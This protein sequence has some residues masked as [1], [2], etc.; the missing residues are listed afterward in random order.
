MGECA[1]DKAKRPVR[2]KKI[3]RFDG[4]SFVWTCFDFLILNDSNVCPLINLFFDCYVGKIYYKLY[5]VV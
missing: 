5:K 4:F 1:K 3:N 2:N